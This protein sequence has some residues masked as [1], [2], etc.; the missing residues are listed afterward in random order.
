M[1]EP[2][3][4]ERWPLARCRESLWEAACQILLVR[5]ELS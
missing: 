5:E 3:T 4:P 1:P 2:E